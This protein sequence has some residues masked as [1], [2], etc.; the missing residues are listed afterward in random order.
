[1]ARHART[2]L[3][4]ALLVSVMAATSSLPP[5]A[6]AIRRLQVPGVVD[7]AAA[8]ASLSAGGPDEFTEEAR[9]ASSPS[10]QREQATDVPASSPAAAE[11]VLA[12]EPVRRILPFDEPYHPNIHPRYL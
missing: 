3:S 8:A 4:L 7:Q 5:Q 12:D 6:Q 10:R 11:R 1:M 2:V 9:E